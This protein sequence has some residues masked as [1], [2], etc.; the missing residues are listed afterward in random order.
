MPEHIVVNTHFINI[1]R[2]FLSGSLIKLFLFT[3]ISFSSYLFPHPLSFSILIFY[4]LSYQII[5]TIQ[6]F[7]SPSSSFPSPRTPACISMPH[8]SPQSPLLSQMLQWIH[9]ISLKECLSP[10][11][12]PN[13]CFPSTPFTGIFD[14]L[15]PSVLWENLAALMFRLK[16][17]CCCRIP[18]S[19]PYHISI[20][21]MLCT[22]MQLKTI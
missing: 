12:S 14:T 13:L 22:F 5:K 10:W 9:C 1:I 11:S 19:K 16:S 18:F 21:F 7:H 8:G 4:I 17:R 3:Y 6:S 2:R 15:L 20:I